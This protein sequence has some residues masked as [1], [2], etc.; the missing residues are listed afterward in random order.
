MAGR[1]LKD[2]VF[3]RWLVL[4]I[5]S[6]VMFFN[7]YFYDA[8]SPLKDLMQDNL[9]FSSSEYGTLMSAYSVPNIFLLMAVLGGIILDKIGIRITGFVF[10]LLMAVGTTI[11]AYGASEAY[12]AGGFGYG[13]MNSFW[14]SVS[15]ALKMM[16][17]GF[18]IFG[19][20]AETSIV[21]LS[22]VIVKW[23][24]G[25]EIA[26]ALGLNLAIGR[27]GTAL[28][29]NLSPAL[30]EVQWT[31]AIWF[32]VMLLWIGLLTFII[33]IF[34]D[35]KIDRQIRETLPHDPEDEFKWRDLKLL[36]TNP[37]FIYITLLCVTFYS[38]VFPFVKYAPDLL[39]NKY[40]LERQISSNIS[41][42]L[43]YGTIALT[44]LF[45]WIADFKGKSATLMYLGS[46]LLIA[47]H[48]MFAKTM[49]P[50]Y[51]PIFILGVAFS[52]V[53][54]AM[55]P[56]VTKIV[57]ENKIGTAY[58]AMFSVQNL[59]LWALP[60]LIGMVLDSS[61]PDYQTELTNAQYVTLQETGEY[62]G[63]YYKGKDEIGKNAE[64]KVKYI[65]HEDSCTGNIVWRAI[66]EVQSGENGEYTIRVG[67][68]DII[69][70]AEFEKLNIDQ[71][72]LGIRVEDMDRK[73]EP[74]I[75]DETLN[76]GNT[77]EPYSGIYRSSGELIS[78]ERFD[79]LI[80][81]Y[82]RENNDLVY[83]EKQ[84]LRTDDQGKMHIEIG[85]GVV[86]EAGYR[87]FNLKDGTYCAEVLTP[88]DYTNSMLMLSLLGVLGLFF[89][90][91]LK[92]DDKTSG[93]GLEKPNKTE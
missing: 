53:P 41:S 14:P 79:A 58:G 88:L 56:A 2:S 82:N 34:L 69:T 68:E 65:V 60:I 62:R 30:A 8:L 75:V 43:M 57:G 1:T 23:F 92:R 66:H 86:Q 80:T 11:T 13:F 25:K 45:G 78:N 49:I 59:G 29:L 74:L 50:P 76:I 3:M 55:W 72:N 40:D 18:F 37:T 63:T 71:Y 21:V 28:A 20:G 70:Q 54:A 90:F 31:N 26:L 48:L 17:L 22:K 93:Y 61:N 38:A 85:E 73:K 16:Y 44:P 83:K 52:L 9:G 19:L 12:L 64:F 81:I 10:I 67:E 33:Y 89:A 47:A 84:N 51:I 42:I 6:A 15:P 32:G 35:I 27:L 36:V 46:V 91:L 4:I 5:S 7:Y 39:M 87:Y 24:K 77:D